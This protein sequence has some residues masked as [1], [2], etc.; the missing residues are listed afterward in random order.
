MKIALYDRD[1]RHCAATA[2]Y[3]KKLIPNVTLDLYE[4]LDN[5]EL[6]RVSLMIADPDLP[7]K[8]WLHIFRETLGDMPLIITSSTP[9]TLVDSLGD[10]CFVMAKP[11]NIADLVEVIRMIRSGSYDTPQTKAGKY[12]AH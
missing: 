7:T 2:V 8:E 1:I 9:N 10:G 3:L 11:Y 4:S 12:G 5:P 6:K